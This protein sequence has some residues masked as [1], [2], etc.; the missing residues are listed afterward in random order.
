M[1]NF[2]EELTRMKNDLRRAADELRVQMHLASMDAKDAWTTLEPKL[3]DFEK[4]FEEKAQEAAD[5][6]ESELE[7]LGKEIEDGIDKIKEA[8]SSSKK[9]DDAS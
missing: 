9:D 8:L 6:A 3:L 7:K 1:S 5:G 2:K 4:Q